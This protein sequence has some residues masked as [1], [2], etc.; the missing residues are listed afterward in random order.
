MN[1]IESNYQHPYRLA[2]AGVFLFCAVLSGC[3]GVH[4]AQSATGMASTAQPKASQSG[5][6]A[7]TAA[8][9][10]AQVDMQSVRENPDLDDAIKQGMSYTELRK[11]MEAHGWMPVTGEFCL[12]NTVGANYKTFCAEHP[13][14]ETCEYC[15]QLPGLVRWSADGHVL[16]LF[17]RA[18]DG[19]QLEIGMYG[20]LENWKY[21]APETML[22]V[23]GWRYPA[24]HGD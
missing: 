14:S 24:K 8:P 13:D 11:G 16:F 19:T 22:G 15:N 2:V 4:E 12:I 7:P 17:E 3:Q 23:S 5:S 6:E 18:S 21:N 1:R 20:E 9:P 10:S